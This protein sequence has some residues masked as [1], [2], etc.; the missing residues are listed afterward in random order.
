MP[1]GSPALAIFVALL[2]AP[3]AAAAQTP[4]EIGLQAAGKSF[5]LGQFAEV[6]QQL[7]PCFEGRT[8]RKVQSDAYS[9]LA[10][11]YLAAD[12]PARARQ[13]VADLLRADPAFEPGPPPRFAQ[14]VAEVRR[15]QATVE[16]TSV[17]KTRE[18]LSEAPATVWVIT[19]EEIERRG[20]LDLEQVLHDMPG[21][22]LRDSLKLVIAGRLNYNAIQN[23]PGAS[24]FGLLFSPRAAVVYI[25]EG[26]RLVLKAIYSEAFKD[27]TDA[28][29]FGTLAEFNGFP[30]G[31][32][33]PERVSNYELAAGWHPND[34]LSFDAA[35]YQAQYSGLAARPA[36]AV[37][38]RPAAPAVYQRPAPR[39]R[40]DWR[41]RGDA[42][43]LELSR[44]AA[45]HDVAAHRRQ[46][47][48]SRLLRD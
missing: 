29:K 26:G 30:S 27:P 11:A 22:K 24:G 10:R 38:G 40:S 14:L 47:L 39:A 8:S 18:S 46:H 44:P 16:V 6:P 2:V 45:R 36:A 3:V 43:D 37:P 32:L 31:G 12:E 17:S 9:L 20:Y 41:P 23:K 48:Q 5:G 28:E 19:S 33:S 35:A 4:C 13:A 42:S 7:A 25:P 21:L 1:E 34:R 15:A